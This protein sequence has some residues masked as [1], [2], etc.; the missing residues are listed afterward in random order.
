MKEQLERVVRSESLAVSDD[1]YE[2]LLTLAN[3][4]MRQAL[5]ILQVDLILIRDSFPR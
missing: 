4:D 1:G 3:G 2:A 5:N